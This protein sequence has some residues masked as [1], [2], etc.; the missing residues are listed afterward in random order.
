MVGLPPEFILHASLV[1]CICVASPRGQDRCRL[2]VETICERL[3]QLS[4]F[5]TTRDGHLANVELI[6]TDATIRGGLYI[7]S[8][9]FQFFSS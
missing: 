1:G 8:K 9:S 4:G 5:S 7:L 2:I 6:A 3:Q